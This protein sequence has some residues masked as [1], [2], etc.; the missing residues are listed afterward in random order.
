MSYLFR[1]HLY[2]LRT[3]FVRVEGCARTQCI[4]SFFEL[5][6]FWIKWNRL[7]DDKINHFGQRKDTKRRAARLLEQN[8]RR[9]HFHKTKISR[10]EGRRTGKLNE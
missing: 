5:C 7:V 1:K 3:L 10:L 9:E 4:D 8:S 6:F 2:R